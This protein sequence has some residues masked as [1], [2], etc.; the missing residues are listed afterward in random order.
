M[1]ERE[2]TVSVAASSGTTLAIPPKAATKRLC[3]RSY[4]MPTRKNSAPVEMPWL[5]ITSRAP[6][7]LCSVRAQMPSVTKP[8]CATDEYAMSFLKSGCTIATRPP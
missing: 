2:T 4:S 7:T 8:R 3:R 5:I 6:C 1:A